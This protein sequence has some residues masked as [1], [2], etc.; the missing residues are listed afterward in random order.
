MATP[1]ESWI[2]GEEEIFHTCIP[3]LVHIPRPVRGQFCKALTALKR[4]DITSE[5]L[6]LR[7]MFHKVVLYTVRKDPR[8]TQSLANKVKLRL[9]QWKQGKYGLLW[10][11][12]VQETA[13]PILPGRRKVRAARKPTDD[14]VDQEEYNGRRARELAET[15]QLSCALQVLGSLGMA[16][17]DGDAMAK[18][19]EKIPTE[20][21][22]PPRLSGQ[23]NDVSPMQITM[24]TLRLALRRFKRGSA[25]GPDGARLEHIMEVCGN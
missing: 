19:R 13:R 4:M 21:P 24:A 23:E 20:G 10:R 25:P 1:E 6:Q 12:A 16:K 7:G 11:T 17:Q 14:V 18:L 2:P 8:D 3:T 5:S 22:L 9:D 15:G